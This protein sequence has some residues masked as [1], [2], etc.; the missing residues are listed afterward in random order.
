MDWIFLCATQSFCKRLMTGYA[1]LINAT[2][3]S[4]TVIVLVAQAIGRQKSFVV[5]FATISCFPQEMYYQRQKWPTGK[6]HLEAAKKGKKM[7]I[8]TGQRQVSY[9]DLVSLQEHRNFDSYASGAKWSYC[10]YLWRNIRLAK[11]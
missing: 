2:T 6:N 7:F 4:E 1:K 11:N 10:S 8:P 3:S 9:V 5:G